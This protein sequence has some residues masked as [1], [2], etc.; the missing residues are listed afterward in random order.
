M[1]MHSFILIPGYPNPH[2]ADL[3]ELRYH[4]PTTGKDAYVAVEEGPTAFTFTAATDDLD[5][6]VRAHA[7]EIYPGVLKVVIRDGGEDLEE[8]M[9]LDRWRFRLPN[10][11]RP[12]LATAEYVDGELI[13][14]VPK[15]A[16]DEE[17]EER[18]EF[19]VGRLV[20]VQ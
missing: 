13:V 6:G 11:T 2:F 14:V 12:R 18:E 10:E 15:G 19:G 5:A 1:P 8:E 4:S 3:A 9:E 17:E 20:L 16:E 7:I